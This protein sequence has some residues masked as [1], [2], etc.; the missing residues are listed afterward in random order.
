MAS[1]EFEEDIEIETNQ[2][3]R[4]L[5]LELMKIAIAKNKTFK[6]VVDEFIKNSIYLKKKIIEK[7]D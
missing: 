6:E 5:T 1:F 3:I 4:M 7:N 2:E